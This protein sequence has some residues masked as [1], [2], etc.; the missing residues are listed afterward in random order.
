MRLIVLPE[1]DGYRRVHPVFGSSPL[2]Q[3]YGYFEI[4]LADGVMLSVI[5]S[6]DDPEWEH[7]SVSLP[8]RCPTWNEMNRVKELFWSDQET[9]LQFH[10]RK[11]QYR[12]VHPYCLHMW[13]HKQTNHVLPPRELIG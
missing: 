7:V 12:N 5:S 6:G 4:P 8:Y 3:S 11:D 1:L 9:V 13:R 10:P 2:R